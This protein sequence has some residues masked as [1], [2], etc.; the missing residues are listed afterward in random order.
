MKGAWQVS[1]FGLAIG[2]GGG[3]AS[4]AG[5]DSRYT[6]VDSRYTTSAI[7]GGVAGGG[8]SRD[9]AGCGAGIVQLN[10]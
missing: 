2:G 5:V 9:V 8:T 1:A 6:G 4:T 3:S 10:F 7:I